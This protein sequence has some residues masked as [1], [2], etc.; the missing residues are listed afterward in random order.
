MGIFGPILLIIAG[1]IL[2]ANPAWFAGA[3]TAGSVCLWF[4]IVILG[5]WLFI[6]LVVFIL[7]LVGG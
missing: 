2:R 1:V 5:L 7:A 3:A 4:G 6:I